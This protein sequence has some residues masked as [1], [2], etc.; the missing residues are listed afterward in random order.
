MEPIMAVA[1]F[2]EKRSA[3][4]RSLTV[5]EAR[6]VSC[7]HYKYV[8]YNFE[9]SPV[10]LSH[11]MKYSFY[12]FNIQFDESESLLIGIVSLPIMARDAIESHNGHTQPKI[13]RAVRQ[14]IGNLHADSKYSFTLDPSSECRSHGCKRRAVSEFLHYNHRL[15]W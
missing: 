4:A 7:I 10:T 6:C 15:K 8:K 5:D 14:S 1:A 13:P 11:C 2:I 12:I 3:V 9:R